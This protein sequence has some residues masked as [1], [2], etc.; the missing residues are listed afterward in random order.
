M[1]TRAELRWWAMGRTRGS[2][3]HGTRITAALGRVR[4]WRGMQTGDTIVAVSSAAG[5][6]ARM[7]VRV[8]GA[9]AHGIA[10][11]L[12]SLEVVEAGRAVEARV[13]P[14]AMGWVYSFGAPRSYTGEDLVEFH[15]PGNPVLGR[16]LLGRI[17][18]LGARQAEAGE[19]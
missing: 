12:T 9:G 5:S 11:E 13:W 3:G 10:R 2:R 16:M 14:G 1:P 15:V 18:E 19:F 4:S 6:G 8:S 17:V 7:I